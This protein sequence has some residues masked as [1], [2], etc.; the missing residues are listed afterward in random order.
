L[1]LPLQ[2]GIAPDDFPSQLNEAWSGSGGVAAE[3]RMFCLIKLDLAFVLSLQRIRANRYP[4][5]IEVEK[6]RTS[7]M[8]LLRGPAVHA[9]HEHD[10]RLD[11]TV[12]VIRSTGVPPALAFKL[13]VF[14]DR[15][16]ASHKKFLCLANTEN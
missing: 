9:F 13:H 15:K 10:I 3:P 8:L 6:V 14:V 11:F 1:V 2:K 12:R 7:G 16:F 4:R 5:V